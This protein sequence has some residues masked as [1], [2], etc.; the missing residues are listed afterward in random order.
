METKQRKRVNAYL[1]VTMIEKH[2]DGYTDDM[3]IMKLHDFRQQI[4]DEFGLKNAHVW[5]DEE[6]KNSNKEN[7]NI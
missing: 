3:I 6:L 1:G 7:I 2:L 5:I 4:E